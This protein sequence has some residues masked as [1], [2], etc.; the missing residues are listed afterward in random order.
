[1]QEQFMRVVKLKKHFVTKKRVIRALDGVSF[2]INQG[3]IFGLL[4]ANGAG[5]TTLSAILATLH[6]A[7]SGDV[8]L[9]RVSIYKNITGYRRVLGYCP[10]KA[11]VNKELTVV[12][13]LKFA[14][15]F[16]GLSEHAV[17]KRMREV[18]AQFKLDHVLHEK[19]DTLSGGYK[20][21]LMLA[22]TLIHKPSIII[23]DEPTVSLDPHIRRQL[24]DLILEL[25]KMGVT[26]ILTT[27]YLDEAEALADRVCILDRGRIKLI[28]T[29]EKLKEL[30]GEATLEDVFLKLMN[31]EVRDLDRSTP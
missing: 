18:V 8:L 16:Y 14:G 19:P 6:P 4:G 22:R 23:L 21:R 13:Q 17:N 15:Y 11:N 27:H 29:P 12:Q 30:H 10:Q 7:T 24:W 5:K 2:D 1:M 9:N 28:E 25:K 20:Q 3:E 26:I 31:E